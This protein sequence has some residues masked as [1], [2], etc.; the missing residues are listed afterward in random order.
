MKKFIL[1]ITLLL[2]NFFFISNSFAL[3]AAPD[4]Y[5]LNNTEKVKL[6]VIVQKLEVII[7]IK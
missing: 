2:I 7:S 4:P 5:E 3:M 6:D 1:F